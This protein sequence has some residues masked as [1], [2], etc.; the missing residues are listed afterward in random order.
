MSVSDAQ[1]LAW[2][3]SSGQRRVVLV[4]ADAWSD[5][6][7]LTRYMATTAFVSAPTD[8]PANT[9]YDDIVTAVPNFARAMPEAFGGRSSMSWGDIEIINEGGVRDAWLADA[10]DG[11]GVRLYLG[12]P[13]WKK[14]DFRPILVGTIADIG[15][16]D[17]TT[18]ILK[19]RDKQQ[20]LNVQVQG[21]L[22]VGVAASAGQPIPL[23]IGP[24]FNVEPV[25]I[26]AGTCT[27]Q[28]HDGAVQAITGV[29]DN[30][31][32]VAYTADV[33]NGKFTLSAAPAGR[34][35]ADVQGA[36]PGGAYLTKI[37][38]IIDH[39]VTTRSTLT[40]AD[41]DTANFAAFAT[42]CPQPVGLYVRDRANLMDLLDQLVGSVGGWYGF[43]RAGLLQ[44][45]QLVAPAGTPALD[46]GVDDVVL[47]QIKVKRRIAPIAAMRIGYA[48]N[49]TPQQDGLAGA[50]TAA[51]RALYGAECQVSVAANAA[52]LSAHPLAQSPDLAPTLLV[53]KTD[54]DAEVSRRLTLYGIT[55]T[56]YELDGFTVPFSINQGDIV[57]LTHPRFGFSAGGLAV[58]A[59]INEQPSKG[60]ATMELFA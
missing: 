57:R 3:Q 28:V 24:C 36:K 47:R 40:S 6:G 59:A 48:K 18:L 4:E 31:I 25:M 30:G 10:W 23:S 52:I 15:A 49:W 12:D 33:A 37:A 58:V 53:N 39:L 22:I 38:D 44:L 41:I 20:A 7:L 11:R 2:L 50:V 56:I 34:I 35:T 1:Y 9:A 51:N 46:I 42:A 21:N 55:R 29:R 17:Q 43:S 19:I 32:G 27:Y 8:T 60:R 26:D 54:A 16:K 13:A 45:G 5:G 14:S